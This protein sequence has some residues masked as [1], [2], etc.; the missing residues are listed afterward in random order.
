MTVW[1]R[2]GQVFCRM[3]LHWDLWWDWGYGFLGERPQR[4]GAILTS[5]QG[6]IYDQHD[7][8]LLMLISSIRMRQCSSGFSIEKLLSFPSYHTALFGREV[9]KHS[10]QLRSG[11]LSSVSLKVKCL[12]KLF[13]IHLHRKA[14]S[15]PHLFIQSFI[16]TDSLVFILYFG[17]KSNTTLFIL[18]LNGSSFGHWELY[19]LIPGSLWRT[20]SLGFGFSFEPLPYFV[21][22]Q[23]APVILHVACPSPRVRHSSTRALVQIWVPF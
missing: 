8:S 6:Y 17:L 1:R 10:P 4:R 5:Y 13:G 12:Q 22:P 15:S 16:S 18:S 14:V 7:I 19:Y 9:I 21:A 2:P 11:E 23:A 20:P 3:S